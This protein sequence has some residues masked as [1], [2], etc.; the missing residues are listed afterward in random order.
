MKSQ[1]K[2]DVLPKDLIVFCSD[3]FRS[4]GISKTEAEIIAQKLVAAN[5]RGVESHGVFRVFYYLEG[6][7]KGLINPKPHIKIIKETEN[8]VTI[9]GDNCIGQVG[10]DKATEIVIKKAKK[11]GICIAGLKNTNHVGML[12]DYAVK[13]VKKELIGLVIANTAPAMAPWGG[14]K[15]L[16]GTN[17]LCIGFPI[18]EN[19][20]IIHDIAT[21]TV[22]AGKIASFARHN[23]KIPTGW[24]HDQNGK[25]TTDPKEALRGLLT[26][27]GGYK[28]YG[29]ALSIDI[30]AGI[31]IGDNIGYNLRL[32]W[33][34][35]GGF[36]I[37]AF[38]VKMF[39]P[40]D[41]YK[42]EILDYIQVLKSCPRGEGVKEILL[43]GELESI[44]YKKRIKNGVPLDL[45]TW[46][47]LKNLSK[48]YGVNLP[49]LK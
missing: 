31:L 19:N 48:N 16:I 42:K 17:P 13:I 26:P 44:E 27:I 35:Q 41:E 23:R 34:T 10:G 22:S 24:A 11:N 7:R 5:L 6:I 36:F 15:M 9:D 39:R 18:D 38:D 28:G 2:G 25:S 47:T 14:K 1:I 3:I 30:L 46:K 29:I 40:Y 37:E 45:P 49:N 20:F 21:S 4:V 12:T 32:S 33:A 43:P 8:I